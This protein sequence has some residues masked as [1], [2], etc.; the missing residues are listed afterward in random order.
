MGP[1]QLGEEVAGGDGGDMAELCPVVPGKKAEGR[2]W[3]EARGAQ[4]EDKE[5][6]FPHQDSPAV[7]PV[8]RHVGPLRPEYS[9][10]RW[11]RA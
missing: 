1:V 5:K 3:D 8:P 6:P 9:H 11:V 2:A 7:Q 4:D 10:P